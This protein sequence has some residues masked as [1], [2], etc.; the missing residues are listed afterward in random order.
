MNP[1]FM[2]S[3]N[4]EEIMDSYDEDIMITTRE[5]I[6][7][8][9]T[10]ISGEHYGVDPEEL[11][12][13]SIFDLESQGIFTPPITPAVVE[14]KK[15]VVTVQMTP[16]GRK[17]LITGIPLFNKEREVE[18]VISYSYE[19]SELIVIKDYLRDLETEMSLVKEELAYW[20]GQQMETGNFIAESASS[21]RAVKTALKMAQFDVPAVIQGEPGVGKTSLAKMIHKQSQRSDGPFI[22][23]NCGTIP[24]GV[25]RQAFTG[26]GEPK[27]QGYLPLAENGTLVLKEVDQ[28]SLASQATLYELLSERPDTCVVALSEEPLEK[29][30][31]QSLFREDLFYFLHVAAIHLKP[32]RER[33]E[34]LDR[35]IVQ[36]LEELN[37]KHNDKKVLEEDVHLHLMQQRWPGNFRELKNVLERSFVESE[38]AVI[39]WQD[40]PANYRPDE[41]ER[42]GIEIDGQTLPH[43]MDVVEKKVLLNAQERYKTTTEMAKALGISQPSVVRKLQKY[44][45]NSIGDEEE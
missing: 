44:T 29:L 28:L 10:Q 3:N 31:E 2:L 12:G 15:K 9:V 23:V 11:L 1:I 27:M 33:T 37:E 22:E 16:S 18:Y 40:L 42:L 7:L 35:A 24:E 39:S 6:I 8:K 41:A 38:T 26:Q 34:D 19:L 17:V 20:R 36:F 32:L 45:N 13:K 30:T 21:V 43:I 4:R 5:G 14:Q 25:F